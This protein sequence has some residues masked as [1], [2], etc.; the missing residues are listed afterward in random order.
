MNNQANALLSAVAVSALAACSPEAAKATALLTVTVEG[1]DPGRRLPVSAAFCA[2]PGVAPKDHNIS[3]AVQWTPGP[4]GT[5]SYVLIM[6]DVDV[7]ADLTLINRP[8]VILGEDTPR[9]SLV[10]WLLIDIPANI[11]RLERGVESDGYRAPGLPVG[12]TS[13]GVRGAN[14]YTYFFPKDSPL[15]SVRGGY[16]GPCPP[17]NDTRPHRYIT[18]IYALDI[19]TLGLEGVFFAD[20]VE[21]KLRDHVLAMGETE[22]ISGAPLK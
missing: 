7:P 14:A 8:G 1:L 5:Q 15:A 20:E 4:P 9:M 18:R 3:P 16:D 19:P 21:R 12:K 10:H 22:A 11:T 2:P 6:T 13:H 17:R